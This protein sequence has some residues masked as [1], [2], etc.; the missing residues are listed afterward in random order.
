MIFFQ[1]TNRRRD[2]HSCRRSK[3]CSNESSRLSLTDRSPPSRRPPVC[4]RHRLAGVETAGHSKRPPSGAADLQR[5]TNDHRQHRLGNEINAGR[6][7]RA[8][9]STSSE[10]AA[11]SN[12]WRFFQRRSFRP[13]VFV[14][15]SRQVRGSASLPVLVQPRFPVEGL[16][17][18]RAAGHLPGHGHPQPVRSEDA[19]DRR[20]ERQGTQG[21]AH[22]IGH[23]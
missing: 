22:F 23:N 21:F 18:S 5:A 19:T 13:P 7:P 17:R 4:H 8:D 11:E 20:R 16:S 2:L 12:R 6:H 3:S 15:L 1:P 14:L 9:R 10:D